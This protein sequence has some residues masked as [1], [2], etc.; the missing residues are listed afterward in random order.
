M[1]FPVEK[2][3]KWL[4]LV[5]PVAYLLPLF[6]VNFLADALLTP[7][8][9]LLPLFL[10]LTIAFQHGQRQTE[11]AVRD[12]Q[13]HWERL[14]LNKLPS[15]PVETVEWLNQLISSLW[16]TF[17]EPKLDLKLL[18]KITMRIN[19]KMPKSL[20]SI[21]VEAFTLGSAPFQLNYP[22][23]YTSTKSASMS[24]LDLGLDYRSEGLSI[25]FAAT[26]AGPGPLKGRVARIIVSELQI[27]GKLRIQPVPSERCVLFAFTE[28][29]TISLKVGI[30]KI[31]VSDLPGVATWMERLLA[32]TIASKM[33][34]P[35]RKCIGLELVDL[36]KQAIG[37][38]LD[39]IV[40]DATGLAPHL[41]GSE[42]FA[43]MTCYG[44][45]RKTTMRPNSQAAWNETFGFELKDDDGLVNV[46][47]SGRDASG[48]IELL[49]TCDVWC[50]Y[51]DDDS[52]CYWTSDKDGASVVKRCTP[53]QEFDV[54]LPLE[55]G[56][57]E[58]HMSFKLTQWVYRA[59]VGDT[60]PMSVN[61]L[62]SPRSAFTG[63]LLSVIVL[64]GKDLVARDTNGKSDPYLKIKYGKE[65][66]TTKVISKTLN[67][68]WNERFE[69]AEM[70][71]GGT[72]SFKCMDQDRLGDEAMGEGEM[73]LANLQDGE[74]KDVWLPL[75]GVESGSIH[76]QLVMKGSS[77]SLSP[78]T[79]P[80]VRQESVPVG[81]RLVEVQVIEGKN[82]IAMDRGNTSDPYCTLTYGK[83]KKKTK[84]CSKTLN[85]VW[86]ETITFRE[87]GS[88]LRVH[89]KDHDDIGRDDS[90]GVCEI[91]LDSIAPGAPVD[92]WVPL[93][94][95]KS[96]LLHFIITI[97]SSSHQGYNTLLATTEKPEEESRFDKVTRIMSW[98][99][100]RF[101]VEKIKMSIAEKLSLHGDDDDLEEMKQLLEQ[102]SARE[103]VHAKQISA[104]KADRNLLIRKIAELEQAIQGM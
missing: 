93:L 48:R 61:D 77:L 11:K 41:P 55:S 92:F 20:K 25:I 64:E 62:L 28:R 56:S 49:G 39:M 44:V 58:I 97:Q 69:F 73:G 31:S 40:K 10:A 37:G 70:G 4:R 81:P 5:P 50:K 84:I 94:N 42:V 34:E 45:T 52:T 90:L 33:V 13:A 7:L 2:V 32:D 23:A 47:V 36:G 6:L 17:L 22:R 67:P 57:G 3:D 60:R 76:V 53:G 27:I 79:K 68:K 89:C 88:S 9:A 66:R 15:T 72:L 14:A 51:M 8:T 30:A 46:R 83:L 29:P 12:A 74:V 95:V 75:T 78:G 1:K 100:F 99:N 19:D 87:D 18:P 26:L 35:K 82:L 71:G 102:V 63:R 54:T 85:P 65:R 21:Q 103:E 104:I 24:A 43:E 96:G 59:G 86:N 98:N 80:P 101:S 91:P 16:P 38:S